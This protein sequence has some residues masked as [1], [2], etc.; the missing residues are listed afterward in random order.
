[1]RLPVPPWSPMVLLLLACVG[2]SAD[3]VQD[4]PTDTDTDSDSDTDTDDTS[5]GRLATEDRLGSGTVGADVYSGTE[6]WSLV[7]EDGSGGTDLCRLSYALTSTAGRSDCSDC[8]WAYDLV[9]SA[10]ALVDEGS[11]GCAAT[12]GDPAALDGTTLAY[13]YAPS[14]FGHAQVLMAWDG[15]AWQAVTFGDM[16]DTTGAFSYD[17]EVGYR[18]Y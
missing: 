16:D 2:K 1:M 4:S 8:A 6:T 3:S 11:P 5:T 13:G 18:T 17:W 9:V 10:T 14:Y 7:A 12:L 15:A